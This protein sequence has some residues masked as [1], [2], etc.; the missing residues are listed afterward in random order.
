MCATSSWGYWKAGLYFWMLDNILTHP[1]AR[2]VAVDFFGEEKY[3][4][5][6]RNFDLH[7]AKDKVTV[8]KSYFNQTLPTMETEQL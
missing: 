1:T 3:R 8:V 7:E 2:A 4:K 5:F 6:K